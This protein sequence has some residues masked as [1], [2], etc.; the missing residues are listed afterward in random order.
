MKEFTI[1]SD[2][3]L[4]FRVVKISPV[5]LLAITT[6]IDFDKYTQT[7]ML[8]KFALEHTEVEQGGKWFPVKTKDREVYCPLGI[9]NN[10]VVLNDIITYFLTEVIGKVF[11]KSSE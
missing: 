1:A 3:T 9:E 5:D 2:T 11:P 8:F 7:Q 4:K 10:L 6:Q